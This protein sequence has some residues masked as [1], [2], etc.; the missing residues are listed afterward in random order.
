MTV[1]LSLGSDEEYWR[2]RAWREGR[3]VLCA[4]PHTCEEIDIL[5]GSFFWFLDKKV[6]GT[7]LAVYYDDT[8]PPTVVDHAREMFALF[9]HATSLF[10]ENGDAF[11][12]QDGEKVVVYEPSG[13]E[14]SQHAEDIRALIE[15]RP[16]FLATAHGALAQQILASMQPKSR[17]REL[18]RVPFVLRWRARVGRWRARLRAW[19]MRTAANVYESLTGR[20]FVFHTRPLYA[21]DYTE[22][23][24]RFCTFARCAIIL[25]GPL[26]L[27][28]SFTLETVRLYRKIFPYADI[29]VSTWEGED[30]NE[31]KSIRDEGAV[32]LTNKQPA[33]RGWANVNLQV[34]SA[35]RGLE[36]ASKR[37]AE[38]ALKIR[39][40]QRIYYSAA[41]E[42]MVSM[43]KHFP[44]GKRS[45]QRKRIIFGTGGPGYSPCWMGEIACGDVV[46]LLE[47]YSPPEALNDKSAY[48]CFLPEL[49]LPSEFLKRKGWK[50]DWTVEQAFEMYRQCFITLDWET[51]DLLWYKY[52]HWNAREQRS[53]TYAVPSRS[54]VNF[55]EWLSVFEQYENKV[56]RPEQRFVLKLEKKHGGSKR[57]A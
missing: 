2:E 49:Y 39:T 24:N 28:R 22:P 17:T 52:D 26:Q 4:I 36:E 10:R 37:G 5:A 21:R 44:P 42:M 34:A 1:I 48:T 8:T 30:E 14:E 18:L 15:S 13:G 12:T 47:Y 50:L 27:K 6:P 9:P 57:G 19:P 33:Q 3:G 35:H 23:P 38:F 54:L 51:L 29:I 43:L 55:G 20:A 25:Q 16:D 56:P 40:D 31:I 46:D 32:V 45:H 41:L 7:F 53:Y 11:V